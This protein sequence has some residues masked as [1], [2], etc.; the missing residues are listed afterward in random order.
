MLVAN[1]Q[2]EYTLAVLFIDKSFLAVYYP[3]IMFPHSSV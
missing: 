3:P 2:G 1:G